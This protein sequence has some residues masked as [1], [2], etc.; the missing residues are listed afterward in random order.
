MMKRHSMDILLT[1]ETHHECE[2]ENE[3]NDI[4]KLYRLRAQC[5]FEIQLA[6][7]LFTLQPWFVSVA[8]NMGTN[9]YVCFSWRAN[10]TNI[11]S[12]Y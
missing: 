7:V 3:S 6:C 1:A 4:A 8:F 5:A 12:F 11:Y 10:V 9:E 2:R